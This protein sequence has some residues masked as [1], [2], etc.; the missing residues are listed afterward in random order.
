MYTDPLRIPRSGSDV[1]RFEDIVVPIA[2]WIPKVFH[3]PLLTRELKNRIH[4]TVVDR[5]VVDR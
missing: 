3:A 2:S 4:C 1:T 5:N